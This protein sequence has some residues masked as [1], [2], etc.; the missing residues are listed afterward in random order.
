[1]I[2]IKH[3]A[4][5]PRTRTDNVRVEY[6]YTVHDPVANEDIVRG[7]SA[8]LTDG[9]GPLAD[10]KWGNEELCAA[11]A[12]TLGVESALVAVADVAV[13]AVVEAR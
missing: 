4:I 8:S 3:Y 9:D 10:Q 1:M 6:E 7:G 13:E 11:L 2:Q 12:R 5:D